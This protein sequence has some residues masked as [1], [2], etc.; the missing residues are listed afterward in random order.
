MRE[1]TKDPSTAHEISYDNCLRRQMP[2]RA[3]MTPGT[4]RNAA[5]EVGAY[6]GFSA[7]SFIL[8]TIIYVVAFI[9]VQPKY[10]FLF[11]NSVGAI[12]LLVECAAWFYLR[13]VRP[14]RRGTPDSFRFGISCICT[15]VLLLYGLHAT[16]FTI[17]ERSVSMNVLRFLAEGQSEPYGRIEKNFVET[18]VSRDKAVCKRLDEQ[19]HLGNVSVQN[20]RYALTPKGVRTF[21]ILDAAGRVTADK[22]PKNAVTC[23]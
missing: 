2:F 15:G 3:L 9:V 6:A 12:L 1:D 21:T 13:C 8:N 4:F 16:V 5:K 7:A 22:I 18:F 17:V 23:E 11:G 10:T 19:I 14:G 20:G